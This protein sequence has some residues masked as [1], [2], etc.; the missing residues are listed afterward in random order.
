VL[1][2]IVLIVLFRFSILPLPNIGKQ[3][4]VPLFFVLG[5]GFLRAPLAFTGA[6][7]ATDATCGAILF[8]VVSA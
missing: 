8:G 1:Q 3:A 5:T 2:W 4:S 6:S 7:V